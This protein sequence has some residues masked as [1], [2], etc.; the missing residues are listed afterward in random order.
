MN[1]NF[2]ITNIVQAFKQRNQAVIIALII[3]ISNVLLCI[4]LFRDNQ[5]VVVVPAHFTQEFWTE[6][7][8]VSK[9]YL[10]E[11]A[12][13]FTDLLFNATPHTMEYQRNIILRHVAPKMY[14]NLQAKLVKEE[15]RYKNENLATTF[16]PTK[17]IV[18]TSKLEVLM[19]G[20]L[21][22]FIS[23]KQIK[24]NEE[25]FLLKFQMEAGRLFMQS[26]SDFEVKNA[27]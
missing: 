23:G 8:M 21:T 11:M 5:R 3:T 18:N 26:F 9:E 14:N 15:E 7:R 19:H 27:N 2:I 12:L 6:R 24:Q 13:F 22:S 10:E 20:Y 1:L 17:I 4:F 25:V 16:S